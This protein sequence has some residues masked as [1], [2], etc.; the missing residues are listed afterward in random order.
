MRRA[1]WQLNFWRIWLP[2]ALCLLGVV[3]L[4]LDGFDLFGVDAFA[5][6]VGAGLSVAL[7]NFLWRIGIAGNRVRDDEEEARRYLADHGRWPDDGPPP[8]HRPT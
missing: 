6:F 2:L 8:P 3:V 1:T 4:I 7:T 5:A